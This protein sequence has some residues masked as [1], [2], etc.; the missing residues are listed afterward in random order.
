[1][2]IYFF[3]SWKI[4]CDILKV[5]SHLI[6][7]IQELPIFF[8]FFLNKFYNVFVGIFMLSIAI[9]IEIFL[10]SMCS[11]HTSS[12]KLSDQGKHFLLLDYTL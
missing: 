8:F 4:K 7:V 5:V 12:A 9:I 10:W 2:N 6:L 11:Q 1:M 3:F